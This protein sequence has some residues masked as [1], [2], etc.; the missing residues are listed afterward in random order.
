MFPKRGDLYRLK[1]DRVGKSRPIVVVSRDALNSGQC[2]LAIPFYSKQLQ[3][4][5]LQKW[6]VFFAK[7]EGGLDCDSVA[8]TDELTLIDK[9][10]IK[11][12]DG[13][14]GTFDESQMKRLVDALKWSLDIEQV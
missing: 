8:K 13:P 9:L 3:K 14:I 10:S 7:D 2:V 6:C 5:R 11:I 4:R 12:S 1:S